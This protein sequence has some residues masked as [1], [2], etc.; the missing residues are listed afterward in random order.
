MNI[1]LKILLLL[2]GVLVA[3]KLLPMVIGAGSLM[4]AGLAGVL[5]IGASIAAVV[6]VLLA[7]LSPLWIPLLAVVGLIV[8]IRGSGRSSTG[9]ST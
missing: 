2:V 6:L 8:L 3:L 1:F 7:L 4:A 5:F 9:I